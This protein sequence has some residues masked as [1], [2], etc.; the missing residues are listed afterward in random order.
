MKGWSSGYW[1]GRKSRIRD[2]QTCGRNEGGTWD[3][4]NILSIGR[5]RAE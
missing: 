4:G 1:G 5:N 2:E 3:E